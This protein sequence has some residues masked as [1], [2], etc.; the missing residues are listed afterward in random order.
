MKPLL[1]LYSALYLTIQLRENLSK[2]DL[3]QIWNFSK[4]PP[5]PLNQKK[6]SP[7]IDQETEFAP[8]GESCLASH[9]LLD[10]ARFWMCFMLRR[11]EMLQ[12]NNLLLTISLVGVYLRYYRTSS[13]DYK[14]SILIE[15]IKC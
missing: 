10:N 2:K 14:G 4:L 9:L 15:Y 7:W 13:Y 1:I 6:K 12:W 3:T 11:E 5:P 8:F